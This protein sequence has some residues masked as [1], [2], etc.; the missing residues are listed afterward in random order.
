MAKLRSFTFIS[1]NGYYKGKNED[2][3]WHRHGM[4]E[5]KYSAKSLKTE[6]ILVFGRVTFEMMESFWQTDLAYEMDPATAKGMN[7]SE[8][9]VF[10][11][12]IKKSNWNNTKVVNKDL[13]SEVKKL[14][15]SSKKDLTILGSG[16]LIKQLSEHKL[17]D[18]YQIMLDPTAIGEGETLFKN[19]KNKLDLKLQKSKVFKSGVILLIYTN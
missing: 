1:L 12:T 6:S 2:I 3:S 9:I 15:K 16:S 10:S 8:K 7:E 17:I 13:I 19:I 4:E 18:E 5:S 11:K 14:K